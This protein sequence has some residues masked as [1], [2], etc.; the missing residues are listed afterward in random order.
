[1]RGGGGGR[2]QEVNSSCFLIELFYVLSWGMGNKVR[3][4]ELRNFASQ[5]S[6]AEA[7]KSGFSHPTHLTPA[8]GSFN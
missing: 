8:L 1:M 4:P 2:L 3:W 7:K 6:E 5:S